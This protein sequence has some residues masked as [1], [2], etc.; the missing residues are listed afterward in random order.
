MKILLLLPLLALGAASCL[1]PAVKMPEVSSGSISDTS[2]QQ[3][4]AYL[5]FMNGSML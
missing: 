5:H 4:D 1:A 2:Q 3:A